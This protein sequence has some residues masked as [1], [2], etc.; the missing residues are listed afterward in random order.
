VSWASHYNH[1]GAFDRALNHI[2]AARS[3]R[4]ESRDLTFEHGYALN[5][6]E[7]YQDA[8][9][10][11]EPGVKAYPRDVNIRAELGFAH[12]GLRNVAKGIEIYERA[13]SMDKNGASGRKAEF[14]QNIAAAYA[15]LGNDKEAKKWLALARK[16]K[17]K[18]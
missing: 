5:A 1:I 17:P 15:Q 3:D 14:A 10:I 11:L 7:R 9:T 4:F 6:M 8:L 13:Y 12:L 16:G 2:N 18:E